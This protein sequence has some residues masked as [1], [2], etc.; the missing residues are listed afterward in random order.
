MPVLGAIAFAGLAAVLSVLVR[1][2][3]N[4]E[5]P[6]AGQ[7][8]PASVPAPATP[9]E[10]PVQITVRS[11]LRKGELWVDG[12]RREAGNQAP[13]N[14]ELAPG[15]HELA[16]HAN[17]KPVVSR[18]IIVEAGK[19]MSLLLTP[20]KKPPTP[21]PDNA[22]NMGTPETERPAAEPLT[23]A[24]LAGIV[25]RNKPQLQ[26]CYE[27]T[28]RQRGGQQDFPIK[29]SVGVAVASNGRTT[30]VTTDGEEFGD[31]NSCIRGVVERWEYPPLDAELEFSFPLVFQQR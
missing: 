12:A 2:K 7:G 31:M 24:Q 13:W 6:Q 9:A 22:T 25:E 20:A 29:L 17:G 5:L 28:L 10:A 19:P 21:R 15:L 16:L 23:A 1:P 26:R 27:T 30:R 14:L 4:L 18:T 11:D 3:P 8:L